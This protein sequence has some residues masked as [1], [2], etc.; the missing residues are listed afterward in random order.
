MMY[1]I[2]VKEMPS[3]QLK[4]N[5]KI[6]FSNGMLSQPQKFDFCK[7]WMDELAERDEL[8]QFLS[9]NCINFSSC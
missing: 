5:I 7:N 9:F 2:E 1:E 4:Q 3:W 6:V 8:E